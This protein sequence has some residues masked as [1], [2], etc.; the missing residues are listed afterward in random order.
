MG[1]WT[2]LFHP[3]AERELETLIVG[4]RAAMLNAVGKL[5]ALGRNLPFPHQSHLEGG[6]RL[7][8]LRPKAGRSRWRGLYGQ[9]GEVF[10]IVAISP[11]AKIDP[12]GFRRAV[13]SAEARRGEIDE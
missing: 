4:E 3:E 5:E 6:T 10:V 8:E 7:R 9:I 12:R 2:V 11:E 13:A 1:V